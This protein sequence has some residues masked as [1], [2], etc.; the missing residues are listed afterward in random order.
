MYIIL[1]FIYIIS[2]P[3][4]SLQIASMVVLG[5]ALITWDLRVLHLICVSPLM[6]FSL[7]L[8]GALVLEVS[9]CAAT[10]FIA[11]RYYYDFF[12]KQKKKDDLADAFLQGLYFLQKK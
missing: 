6:V 9:E 3:L 10:L 8:S 5:P 2:P 12:M 7:L 11:F 1:Y 4:I